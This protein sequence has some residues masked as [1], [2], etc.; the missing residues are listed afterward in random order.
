MML[1]EFFIDENITIPF[2]L[3]GKTHLFLLFFV[4]LFWSILFFMKKK[5]YQLK[6][7]TKRRITVFFA[8]VL[9][10]N[11]LVLYVSSFYY[12]SFDY[13]TM[14]PLHLCYI[15]NYFYIFVILF[16]KEK[17]YQ[18]IYFLAFLGPIPAILFFDVPSV[19]ES[20]NFYLYIISHHVL[21]IAGLFTFYM[22]PKKLSF[23]IIFR[24]V[25]ILNILYIFMSIFN[26][27]FQT[28]YFFSEAIPEFILELFPFL[29][30]IPIVVILEFVEV[31]I[32]VILYFFFK[33]EYS[34]LKSNIMI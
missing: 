18:Y 22:Y 1:K 7:K 14:L 31:V 23:K 4:L 28:N 25:V 8:I 20:F 11:M 16:Y 5:I 19:W 15:S 17:L 3:F 2:K 30:H 32:I 33:R 6:D 26:Y 12:H 21:V 34:L 24:L 29:V 13:K 27:F 10:I 9:L